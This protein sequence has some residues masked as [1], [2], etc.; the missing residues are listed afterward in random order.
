MDEQGRI[1]FYGHESVGARKAASCMRALRFSRGEVLRARTMTEA[2]LRPAHL[3]RGERV[4]RRAIY[5]YFHDTGDAGVDTVLLSLADHL[6]TWGPNLQEARWTNRLEVAELLLH[7][8]FEQPEEVI[9]PQLPVDGHDLMRA[10][11]L[12]PGPEV[13]RLLDLLREAVAA[14]EVETCEEVLDLA[15]RSVKWAE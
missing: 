15:R 4:T 1:H 14:G 7:H 3:A 5:R 12:E 13:G 11:D 8:Y 9:D 10:L 6:A 2:H